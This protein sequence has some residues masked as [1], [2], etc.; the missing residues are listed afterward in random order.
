MFTRSQGGEAAVMAQDDVKP[1]RVPAEELRGRMKGFAVRPW[2]GVNC[3][4]S[5]PYVSSCLAARYLRA[6]MAV[7]RS[8]TGLIGEPTEI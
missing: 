8:A 2:H 6:G 5:S 3:G 4:W 1:I 7:R